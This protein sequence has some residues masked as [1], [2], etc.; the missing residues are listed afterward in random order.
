MSLG[1]RIVL[2]VTGVV[3]LYSAGDHLLQRRTLLPSFAH[4]ERVQAQKDLARAIEAIRAEIDYLDLAC[5]DRATSDEAWAFVTGEDPEGARRYLRADLGSG[6]MAQDE[7]DLLYVCDPD[8]YVLWG[9]VRDWRS[10]EALSLRDLPRERLSLNHPYLV[11]ANVPRSI[12]VAS[13]RGFV[14]GLVLTEHRPSSRSWASATRSTSPSGRWTVPVCRTRSWRCSRR[15]PR[16]R[17]QSLSSA[18]TISSTSIRRCRT[19][20]ALPRCW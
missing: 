15:S 1:T 4:L 10:G 16:R 9:E 11:S 12:E 3:A 17:S 2:I 7:I 5:R 6:V 20:A 8:G 19:C 14:S 18:E 13:Q